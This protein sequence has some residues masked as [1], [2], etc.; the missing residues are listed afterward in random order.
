MTR[1]E[2]P[3]A[4]CNACRGRQAHGRHAGSVRSTRMVA[5]R[6]TGRTAAL[7][8]G[9]TLALMAAPL[10]RAAPSADAASTLVVI[11]TPRGSTSS[12][13]LYISGWAAD[14]RGSGGGTGVD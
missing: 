5:S 1:D 3:G 4:S 6:I 9:L 13:Q 12:T 14:P 2:V 10:A 11:D 7:V 8:V